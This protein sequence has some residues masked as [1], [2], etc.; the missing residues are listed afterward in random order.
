MSSTLGNI[1]SSV[2]T[3]NVVY[4]Y[5]ILKICSITN[6]NNYLII[7]YLLLYILQI[8]NTKYY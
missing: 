4:S 3:Y 1:P 8:A 5:I 7:Y 6:V 2:P